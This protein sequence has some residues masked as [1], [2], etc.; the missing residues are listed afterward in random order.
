MQNLNCARSET[1]TISS[2]RD[3]LES[4]AAHGRSTVTVRQ[5]W[6]VKN[7]YVPFVYDKKKGFVYDE[8]P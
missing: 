4:K 2:F 3:H 6:N 7:I 8:L 5:Q 1:Q